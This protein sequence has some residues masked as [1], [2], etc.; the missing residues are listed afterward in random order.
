MLNNYYYFGLGNDTEGY[1]LLS[2]QNLETAFLYSDYFLTVNQ[3]FNRD[4]SDYFPHCPIFYIKQNGQ[5]ISG[6]FDNV[7]QWSEN[8]TTDV[9]AIFHGV[10]KRTS[11]TGEPIVRFDKK[12][13]FILS[14]SL[15]L[16][17]TSNHLIKFNQLNYSSYP[18]WQ[19]NEAYRLIVQ[20][21][22]KDLTI[23]ESK[24]QNVY[25]FFDQC[26]ITSALIDNALLVQF[27][28]IGVEKL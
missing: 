2:G 25:E 4:Y 6:K 21:D 26:N 11:R 7:N 19:R 28:E 10:Y 12:N 24:S 3:F 17:K 1:T 18:Y 23:V 20:P 5:Q 22:L 27:G 14:S 15:D 16:V 8:L 9:N 13:M